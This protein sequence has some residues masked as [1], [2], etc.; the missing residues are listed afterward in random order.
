MA[1]DRQAVARGSFV[2]HPLPSGGTTLLPG[3]QFR[4]DGAWEARP[5]PRLGEHTDAILCD[6]GYSTAER[7]ALFRAAVTG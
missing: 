2:E 1:S 7:L 4:L 6:L 3:P 5:A